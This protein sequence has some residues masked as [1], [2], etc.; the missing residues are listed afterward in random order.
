MNRIISE[1]KGKGGERGGGEGRK[2]ADVNT[3]LSQ[4]IVWQAY[5]PFDIDNRYNM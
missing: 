3:K 5:Y 4:R 2:E 1:Y